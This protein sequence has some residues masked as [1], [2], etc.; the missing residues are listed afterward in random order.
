M[1][2]P[3]TPVPDSSAPSGDNVSGKPWFAEWFNHPLY[4]KVYSHRDAGEAARCIRTI[5]DRT[6]Q[7]SRPPA[8]IKVLDIAC[9]AGRHA[10]ELARLGYCVTGND[11][12]PFLLETA[13]QEALACSIGLALTCCDMRELPD[14]G[15]YDLVVQL[16][17]S[18]GYFETEEDD[19]R[20]LGNVRQALKPGGW[21]VLD[22]INPLHLK[23]NLVEVSR[24]RMDNLSVL[25]ERTLCES[26]I[27]KR[28]TI[29]PDEGE[30]LVFTESVRL[31]E[32][33]EIVG[34]LE[35]AGFFIDSIVGDYSGSTFESELSPR[36][37]LFSKK[38]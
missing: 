24:R 17:T 13:R 20:V 37:M 27:T 36:M 6:Q 18:F 16:F 4:L 10:L 19:L 12:S 23:R 32:R 28:I 15:G 21:Y 33:E 35:K 3:I 1:H 26:R 29:T 25:E 2:N 38:S 14:N 7:A 5:V 34:M 30:P 8:S 22:L 31:F 9:G 11:L